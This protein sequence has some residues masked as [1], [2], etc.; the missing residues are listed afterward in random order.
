MESLINVIEEK[1]VDNLPITDEAHQKF[2]E[3]F[4]K[5]YIKPHGDV[6]LQQKNKERFM[7]MIEDWEYINSKVSIKE[8]VSMERET[9]KIFM[10][11]LMEDYYNNKSKNVKKKLG[12]KKQNKFQMNKNKTL[13]NIKIMLQNEMEKRENED[14]SKGSPEIKKYPSINSTKKIDQDGFSLNSPRRKSFRINKLDR[15]NSCL[16]SS[17]NNDL[18]S[19]IFQFKRKGSTIFADEKA[20][21]MIIL[22]SNTNK[23]YFSKMNSALSLDQSSINILDNFIPKKLVEQCSVLHLDPDNQTLHNQ[24]LKDTIKQEDLN[25]INSRIKKKLHVEMINSYKNSVYYGDKPKQKPKNE[26]MFEAKYLKREM[27]E[28]EAKS[29]QKYMLKDVDVVKVL[30]KPMCEDYLNI[31]KGKIRMFGK[32]GDVGKNKETIEKKIKKNNSCSILPM[33]SEQC[34]KDSEK[35]LKILKKCDKNIKLAKKKIESYPKIKNKLNNY[36][37]KKISRVIK[38]PEEKNFLKYINKEIFT[39]KQNKNKDKMNDSN[40]FSLS[41]FYQPNKE[42][43]L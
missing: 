22:S 7:N 43:K 1:M 36:V 27:K 14:K 17:L 24:I 29:F 35:T 39:E 3:V 41:K 42:N 28:E 25:L 26:R 40:I 8:F 19:G 4:K 32:T 2:I 31:V 38:T 21:N 16:F 23:Y 11:N 34:L 33:R 30:E 37:S 10:E 12:R 9:M 6:G 20:M 5:L 15:E 13:L 18:N